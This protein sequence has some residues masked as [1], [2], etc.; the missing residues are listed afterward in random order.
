[1][2]FFAENSSVTVLFEFY[3]AQDL[4]KLTSKRSVPTSFD[5]VAMVGG[6]AAGLFLMFYW[7]GS[8]FSYQF[9][10]STIA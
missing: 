6:F 9:M 4:V 10:K 5:L 8:Y 3:F 1:M 7:L 2:D